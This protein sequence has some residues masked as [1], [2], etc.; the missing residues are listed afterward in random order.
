MITV[1]T[2]K[3]GGSNVTL[4]RSGSLGGEVWKSLEAKSG[5]RLVS[6]ER[7]EGTLGKKTKDLDE[8]PGGLL[9]KGRKTNKKSGAFN[10]IAGG[11][12]EKI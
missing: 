8:K 1:L 3:K 2:R 9:L 7:E 5:A 4:A 11:E 12:T 6:L 10:G